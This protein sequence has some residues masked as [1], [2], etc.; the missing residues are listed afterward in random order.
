M[1]SVEGEL[2][3][4]GFV[5][6]IFA[7][8]KRQWNG[9]VPTGEADELK[10][11]V[12]DREVVVVLLIRKRHVEESPLAMAERQRVLNVVNGGALMAI[13]P[14]EPI[15]NVVD[16]RRQRRG[17]VDRQLERHHPGHHADAAL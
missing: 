12:A 15:T 8:I 5:A 3:E 14:P 4:D 16:Q 1:R 9:F 17:V 7:H 10:E 13:I 6:V 11:R 2:E